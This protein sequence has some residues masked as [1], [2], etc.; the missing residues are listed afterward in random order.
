M[1]QLTVHNGA[2]LLPDVPK[3]TGLVWAREELSL[4]K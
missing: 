2:K 3:G 4:S 1:L